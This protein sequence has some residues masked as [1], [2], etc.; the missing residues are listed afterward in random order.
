MVLVNLLKKYKLV[1]L[2]LPEKDKLIVVEFFPRIGFPREAEVGEK[3]MN[4]QTIGG[5]LPE[6]PLK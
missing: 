2:V 5:D 4:T 6:T 3:K 1:E